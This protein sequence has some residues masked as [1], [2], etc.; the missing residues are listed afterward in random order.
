MVYLVGGIR[1][2]VGLRD[3]VANLACGMI[4]I[5]RREGGRYWVEG[6]VMLW[7]MFICSESAKRISVITVNAHG[8]QQGKD[9][10]EEMIGGIPHTIYARYQDIC[11]T[12]AQIPPK[13]HPC[14]SCIQC[15]TPCP[16]SAVSY[17]A[18]TPSW[19]L[20]DHASTPM[21]Q[22][23]HHTCTNLMPLPPP[24]YSIF[25]NLVVKWSASLTAPNY[26]HYPNSHH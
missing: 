3:V 10:E 7:S 17:H 19:T 2:G 11:Q 12:H 5:E 26:Q 20:I 22:S 24:Q 25:H 6:W 21:S 14:R 16:C 9:F 4:G 1:G 23:Y 13:C 18:S 15:P 8:W